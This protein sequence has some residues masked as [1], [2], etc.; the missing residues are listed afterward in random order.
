[1]PASPVVPSPRVSTSTKFFYGVGSV[2]FG[3]KDNGFS[4][5]LLFYYNQVL[6]LPQAWVGAGIM[7]TLL[8]DAISDPLVGYLSDNWHSRWGRRHPFLYFSSV[9]VGIGFWLLFSPP[10]GLAPG[11]LFAWF[12]GFAI[13]VRTMITFYEIPSSSLVAELTD[14]YDQ[15]TSLMSFR[16]FFGWTGGLTMSVIAYAFFLQP[17]AEYPNGQLNPAGYHLYAIA[18][19]TVITLAILVSAIGTHRH[20]PTLK[21]P[22]PKQPF[23]WQRILGE[24]KETLGNHSF[25]VLFFA[26]IFAATAA[27][28]SAALNIYFNTY[29]WELTSA[30]ISALTLSVF[31][32]AFVGLLA[33]PTLATR[34]GKKRAA[35]L[36]AGSA[37]FLAPMAVIG[38]LFGWM[39]ENGSA[40]LVPALMVFSIIDVSLIIMAGILVS[41]MVADIVE[42][43]EIRTGRRS[44]GTFFAA[45]SFAQKAVSGIGVWVSTIILAF[46]NFPEGAKPGQVPEAV[47]RD[48]A[49]TY[50]P[51]VAVLYL[52]FLGF[53]ASYRISRESHAENLRSLADHDAA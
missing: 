29:F 30:Q 27:G 49:L 40:F 44:E 24:F 39:P 1:M 26:G 38:R 31:V 25:L 23:D 45:R 5:F 9:P 50:L 32:A 12:L 18:C 41:S 46:V 42:E 3:V 8:L 20:I 28:L 34:L 4:F 36:T 37:A 48:L 2:A 43:S 22:P 11:A 14:D 17:T 35:L 13:L 7:I 33:T 6:G 21:A 47:L 53:L 51:I 19:G 16:Y 15:R 52:V 10:A